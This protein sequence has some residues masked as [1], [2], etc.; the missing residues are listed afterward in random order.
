MKRI[1]STIRIFL[2]QELRPRRAAMQAQPPAPRGA[3]AT[4]S[5]WAARF[6]RSLSHIIT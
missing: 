2:R 3:Y 5:P 1:T 4:R 6:F